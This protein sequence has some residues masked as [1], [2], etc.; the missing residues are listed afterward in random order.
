MITT[1]DE[2]RKVADDGA[3]VIIAQGSEA[4][5]HRSTFA[6]KQNGDAHLVV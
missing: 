2:A 6:L 5:G 3:D 1:V 4:G